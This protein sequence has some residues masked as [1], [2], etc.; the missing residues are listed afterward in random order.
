MLQ[1][2]I[3]KEDYFELGSSWQPLKRGQIAMRGPPKAA[4]LASPVL[5]L[6]GMSR[7]FH[8]N[9]QSMKRKFM[10]DLCCKKTAITRNGRKMGTN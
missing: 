10:Q 6:G 3:T 4:A 2:V 7:G 9:A 1:L 8:T 5:C